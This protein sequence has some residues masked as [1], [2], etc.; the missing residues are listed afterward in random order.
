MTA[1]GDGLS[2]GGNEIV[3]NYIVVMVVQHFEKNPTE[4]HI[5]EG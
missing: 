4:L 1:N 2:S 3:L 5:L